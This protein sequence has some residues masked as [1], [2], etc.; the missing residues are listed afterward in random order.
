VGIRS[1]TKATERGTG[2]ISKGSKGDGGTGAGVRLT[3]EVR[4][5]ELRN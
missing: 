2:E 3:A 1:E 4:V 5:V